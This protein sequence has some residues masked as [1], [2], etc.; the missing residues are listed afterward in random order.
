MRCLKENYCE[1]GMSYQKL[2][3]IPLLMS[4]GLEFP[5][6]S[7]V[8]VLLLGRR[9]GQN[10]LLISKVRIPY[11]VQQGLGN[12]NLT[13]RHSPIEERKTKTLIVTPPNVAVIE[14][15]TVM[16]PTVIW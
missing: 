3:N 6:W 10:C 4:L 7:Q 2:G 11:R 1:G 13:R 15:R 12:C 9:K 14:V 8:L 16:D 5:I